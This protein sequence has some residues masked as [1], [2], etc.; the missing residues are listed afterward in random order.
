MAGFSGVA[1][2]DTEQAVLRVSTASAKQGGASSDSRQILAPG[3]NI[4]GRFLAIDSII[5]RRALLT[6][7]EVAKLLNVSVGTLETWR[8]KG[9]RRGRPYKVDLPFIKFR[10]KGG[11]VRYV[12]ADLERWLDRLGVAQKPVHTEETPQA[13]G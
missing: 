8:G 5:R 4:L 13:R 7:A 2:G 9:G 12:M 3:E 6:P 11:V 10:E 1:S